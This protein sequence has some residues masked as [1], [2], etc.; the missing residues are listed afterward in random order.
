MTLAAIAAEAGVSLSTMSKV[1]NGRPDVSAATRGRLEALLDQHGYLRRGAGGG[2]GGRLVELVFHELEAA[3]SMEIIKG[4]EDVAAD[5]GMS[6]VLTR[7][8]SRHSPDPDWVEGV[9]SRRPVGVVL[10][11]SDLPP[12]YRAM[13]RSRAIPFVIIDPAGDPS[14]EVPSVGSANWSGGL[15]ATRHLIE[16]GHTRIAAITGPE[17]MMCSHARIDGF[18]SAMTAAGLPIRTDW[19]RFGDFHT[20]G[21]KQHGHELLRSGERPTAIFAGSDLQALGV[22]EAVRAL[23][24]RVPE[25]LSVV[26]YDDIPLATWV[27]PRLTTI[28]QPLKRMAEE[29]T[30]LVLQM[31]EAPLETVPRMD[32]ATSLV[33]RESTAAPA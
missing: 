20:A 25:D 28:R 6:V 13:L 30:R 14:P 19:I 17:D 7:S 1:L 15:M 12:E 27:S 3:W 4:V 16:L 18:R 10:V 26:G 29:A 21:G 31:A 22:L 2:T 32:L 24:L 33:V 11:F 8:G 23:G 5:H 9:L